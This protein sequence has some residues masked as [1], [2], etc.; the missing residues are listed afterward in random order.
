MESTSHSNPGVDDASH[1]SS[2]MHTDIRLCCL[3]SSDMDSDN[4]V[5]FL[6]MVFLKERTTTIPFLGLDLMLDQPIGMVN[7]EFLVGVFV[8]AD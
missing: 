6:F 7:L 2:Q 8:H 5:F 1:F 3:I 4:I